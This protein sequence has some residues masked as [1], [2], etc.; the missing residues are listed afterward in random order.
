MAQKAH[1]RVLRCHADAVVR[2]ADIIAPSG[3]ELQHNGARS[4]VHRVFQKLLDRRGGTL[5]NFARGNEIGNVRRKDVDN[6]HDMYTSNG[7]R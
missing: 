7:N 2:D 4:G 3:A 5:D 6:R 1:A